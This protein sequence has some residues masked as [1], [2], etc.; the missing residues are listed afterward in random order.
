MFF[1]ERV[2]PHSM[3]LVE[4]QAVLTVKNAGA[5][6]PTNEI[7]DR[8]AT[9]RGERERRCQG[10]YVEI[11]LGGKEARGDEQRISREKNAN[12]QA[13][14]REDDGC[15]TKQPRPLDEGRK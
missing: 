6:G 5:R 3:L 2:G 10:V 14:F 9:D 8:I 15:N 12:Q 1:V 11:S 7:S 4:E 13:R